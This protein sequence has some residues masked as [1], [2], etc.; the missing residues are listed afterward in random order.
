MPDISFRVTQDVN[1]TGAHQV[2]Y[3]AF[4]MRQVRKSA[5]LWIELASESIPPL[6][7]WQI[8]PLVRQIVQ[9]AGEGAPAVLLRIRPTR[10]PNQHPR[11]RGF[12]E[13]IGLCG[14]PG[15]SLRCR[16]VQIEPVAHQR[17]RRNHPR[18]NR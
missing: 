5:K 1:G 2:I 8:P 13:S 7:T 6:A 12:L 9:P 18:A 14:Q 4:F 10:K 11:A 15:L 3:P 16:C 17:M